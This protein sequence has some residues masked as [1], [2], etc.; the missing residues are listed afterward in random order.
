MSS[1]QAA[2]LPRPGLY[3]YMYIYI[4]IFDIA[5]TYICVNMHMCKFVYM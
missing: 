2:L 3:V 1:K 5:Y 4:H